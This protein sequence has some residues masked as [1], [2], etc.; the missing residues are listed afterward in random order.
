MEAQTFYQLR[1]ELATGV[2]RNNMVNV[3]HITW[4]DSFNGGP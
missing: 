3:C 2:K 1:N 4:E